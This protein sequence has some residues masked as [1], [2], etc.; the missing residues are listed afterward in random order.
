MHGILDVHP[1][2]R[3]LSMPERKSESKSKKKQQHKR[4]KKKKKKKSLPIQL[5]NSHTPSRC[6][7]IAV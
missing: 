5:L 4:R 3:R 1:S 6:M 7:N 2:A